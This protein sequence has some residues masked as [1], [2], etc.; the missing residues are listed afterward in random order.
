MANYLVTS[1]RLAGYSPGDVVS[2]ADLEGSNID[3]LIEAGHLSTQTPK[4]PAKPK[5]IETEE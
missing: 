1:A 3:A 5:D 4:K 2:D